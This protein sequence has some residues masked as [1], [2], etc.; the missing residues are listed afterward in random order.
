MPRIERES[1]LGKPSIKAGLPRFFLPEN[2]EENLADIRDLVI[3]VFRAERLGIYVEYES[4][5]TAIHE[6]D[7]P[8]S[9]VYEFANKKLHLSNYKQLECFEYRFSNGVTEYLAAAP[10]VLKHTLKLGGLVIARNESTPFTKSQIRILNIFTRDI[11]NLFVHQQHNFEIEQSNELHL[12]ISQLN[13]DWIFVKDDEFRLVYVNDAFLQVYPEN[14][15]DNVI[16]TTTIEEYDKQEAENFLKYDK[17]A[18]DVGISRTIEDIHMPDGSHLIINTVKRRFEDKAGNP[19]ILCVCRDITEKEN[20]IRELKKANQE[21][22]DF[23]SIA[24]H[25]LKAPLNAIRRLIAWIEEETAELLPEGA[26]ANMDLVVNRADRMQKLLNDLLI[27]AKISRGKETTI[28][29]SLAKTVREL[30]LLIDSPID[31]ELTVEDAL[32]H[33]PE[34]PLNTV[35]LNLISNA[36]KHNDKP[37]P[38]LNI[39][40]EKTRHYYILKIKDNGP[41]IAPRFQKRV[42]QLFQTLKPRDEVEGT[43]MGLSVVK[44]YVEFYKGYIELNSDGTHGTEFKVYWPIDDIFSE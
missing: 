21:L 12:L 27:F 40:F 39:T 41:G 15:R 11:Q 26:K 19:Y 23:A 6:L 38:V 25:D 42:F 3:E 20:L 28:A 7:I 22:D 29:L 36:I 18:F 9:Q 43:G 24:S 5:L 32:M 34:V 1:Y 13:Q 4:K 16:G 33:V 8:D 35:L 31:Y 14:M 17:I 30:R 10:I 37:L 2:L 44:K